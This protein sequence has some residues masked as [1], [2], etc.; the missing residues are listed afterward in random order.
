MSTVGWIAK[1]GA[2]GIVSVFIGEGSL[3]YEYFFPAVMCVKSE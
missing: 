2:S 1:V 3:K